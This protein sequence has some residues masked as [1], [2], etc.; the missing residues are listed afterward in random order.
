MFAWLKRRKQT[1]QN[2]DQ[3]FKHIKYI[4]NLPDKELA[5]LN[6]LLPWASYVNDISGRRFGKPYSSKKRSAPENIPDPRIIELDR[7][8]P[9][10]NLRILEVGCFEGNHT[11][12]LSQFSDQVTAI[13]SRIEHVV[14]TI[15]RTSM[16]GYKPTVFHLDLEQSFPNDPAL[17]FDVL[18]HVGVLYH[19]TDPIEHLNDILPHC[20]IIMLDTHIATENE[21]LHSYTVQGV[22]YQYKKY[23]EAGRAAPFA[24]MHDHAKWLLE[25]DILQILENNGF[26]HIEIAERRNE[27]NG[28]RILIYAHKS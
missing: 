4:D 21:T 10:H 22:H 7:R 9:L 26:T 13:D 24:G 18:H 27:R 5:I 3:T 25:K 12:A 17:T 2:D 8:Y 20:S 14:K 1:Q 11:V 19:L 15:I 23:H 28:P 6:N 16:F